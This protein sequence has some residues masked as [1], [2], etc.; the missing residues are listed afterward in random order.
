MTHK[1]KGQME[2]GFKTV[3]HYLLFPFLEHHDCKVTIQSFLTLLVSLY[4]PETNHSKR[5]KEGT[6]EDQSKV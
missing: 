1:Q 2:Q 5:K 6:E 4:Q 3:L